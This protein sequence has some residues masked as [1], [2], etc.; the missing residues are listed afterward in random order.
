MLP[1]LLTRDIQ[2]GLKQF[3]LTGFEPSDPHLHGMMARFTSTE[4]Q[5]EWLKGPYLQLGLPFRPGVKGRNFFSNFETEFPGFTHQE[6]AWQRLNT[7]SGSDH[8]PG[9]TLVATGTGSGKTECFVYPMLDH[10]ARALA[11]GERGIK[12]LVIYPMNA[13]ATDQARRLAMMVASTPAFKGLRIGLFV[14]GVTEPGSGVAMTPTGVITDRETM[15]KHPPDVLLTNYKMLDYLLLRPTDRQLWKSNTPTTL[16]HL[17]VD[18]L[19]TF[20][21]A[22]GTDLALLLRRLRARL[23]VPVNHWLCVGT[24]ATL[25]GG[26]G[27]QG[28]APL[29][30]YA[31]QI[32]GSPFPPESVVTE[33]RLLVGEFL[34]DATTDYFLPARSD[35]AEVLDPAR[36]ASPQLAVQAWFTVFFADEATPSIEDVNSPAWRIRLGQMLKH[37]LL[38]SNLLKRVKGD[39]LDMGVLAEQMQGKALPAAANGHL[40]EVIDALLVLVS[41]ARSPVVDAAVTANGQGVVKT[42]PLV[43]VRVQLWLRE[44]RRMVAN[45]ALNPGDVKLQHSSQL[46]ANPGGLHLPLVQCSE[47][48]TTGWLSR[49]PEGTNKLSSKLEEIY[50]TWFAGRPDSTRLY[51]LDGLS[52]PH[53]QVDGV[54]R[55]LCTSCGQL[56][57]GNG[58]CQACGH[59]ELLGVF[60][61]TGLR[62]FTQGN[63]QFTRHDTACP[64]CGTRDRL[65]LLGARNATLGSQVVEHSW[66]SPFNDDKKLIAF[67]DS[68]Q[69][70]A[71]RAGFFGAR[72]YLN[73]VRTALA[74][75]LR[76]QVQAAGATALPWAG[77]LANLE[78][79]CIQP[80]G[81]LHMPADKFVSEFLGP[82]MTW[83]RD[84]VH[85]LQKMGALPEGS[86]LPAK[87]LKRLLWQAYLEFTYLGHRGRT[88]ERV[89]V[90]ALGLPLALLQNVAADL[91]P[92][93]REQFGAQGLRET[94]VVHWLWGF[95]T[96]LR[97]CGAVMHPELE[98]YAQDGNVFGLLRQKARSDWM[99]AMGERTPRP[100]FLSLGQHKHFETLAGAATGGLR[101]NWYE[102]WAAATLG[103]DMLLATGLA[104]E[105]YLT[106]ISALEVAGAMVR[107][108]GDFGESI[109]LAPQSLQLETDLVLLT[110]SAGT[111]RLAVPREAAA[112]LLDMPC[113]DATHEHYTEQAPARG[114]LA[115]R[116]E[117]ADLRRVMAAEHTGLLERKEREAL[118]IRFKDKHPKPWF[119]N[120]LSATPTLEMGVDIGDLSQ[121]LLCS[122]P[123]NQASFL[124]RV[125][126][127]GRRD[128]NAMAATLADGSSPHDL[129]FFDA[130]AE[131]LAGEVAP[132]GV[133][134][135]AAE[136]LRRQLFAYCMDDWVEGLTSATALPVKTST[137]LDAVEQANMSRFPYTFA[138]HV[139]KHEPRL[140]QGFLELLDDDLDDEVRGRLTAFVQGNGDADG[141]RTRLIKA[142]EELAE[143]R[144]QHKK[145][146]LQLDVLVQTARQRPKDEATLAEIDSLLRERDKMLELIAEINGRELLNTLTDAGLIPNYAFPEAGIELKSVL[147]RARAEGEPG[148][149]KYVALPALKYER[150]ANSALSEFAPENRFYA[151]QRRVEVDQINM[152][153][154]K[155]ERWRLCASCHH[156][157]NLETSADV[158]TT[159]PR[160]SDAMWSDE[161]QKRMLLRFKQAIANS[162]DTKVR[163]DDS[164]DDREPRFYVRQLLA[165]FE[166]TDVREAWQLKTGTLPFGF[167]FVSKVSFRDMNFGELAKPGETFKVAD[168]EAV[169]A[170]FKLCKHC[171]KVQTP[172]KRK[173]AGDDSAGTEQQHSFDCKVRDSN[174]PGNIFDCLYLYREFSSEALR[175]LVPYTRH[176]VD[177]GVVQSFMAALQLGLK[178]RFGGKVDHLRV[179]TQDEPGKDGGARRHYVMVYDS[180]PGGTGYLHQLLAGKAGTLADVLTLALA[181]ITDCPCNADPDK[182]GCYR[183][184]YQYR[185]GR[186]MD[187]VSR[188]R[189]REVLSELV[190]AL[191]DMERVKTISEIFINPNFDSVLEARFIESLRRLGLPEAVAASGLPKTKLVQ[192]IVNG[193]SGWLLEVG[194][195]RYKVQPQCDLGPSDGVAVS[196]RPDFVL[197]PWPAT[198]SGANKKR[199]IAVFCDGWSFHKNSIRADALKRSALVAS[200]RFWVWS[201][202]HDDVKAALD[203][204]TVTD[205]ESPLVRMNRHDGLQASPTLARAEKGAFAS[206]G[207]AQLL[208]WLERAGNDAEVRAQHNAI[209]ASFLMACPPG[210]TEA[211]AIEATL[212]SLWQALPDWMH[213]PPSKSL[214]VLSREGVQP[215]LAWRW[216]ASLLKG[217]LTEGEAPGLLLLD[218][219]LADTEKTLHLQWRHWLALFNTMQTLPGFVMMSASGLQAGDCELLKPTICATPPVPSD[220]AALAA[221]WTATLNDTLPAVHGGLRL[222][223]AAGLPPPVAGLE[224]VDGRGRVQAE[225][226][227]AWQQYR[228]AVLLPEQADLASTWQAQGWTVVLVTEEVGAAASSWAEAILEI[229][230]GGDIQ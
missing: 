13:L 149:G 91:A 114:W 57:Q 6:L 69:D 51:A 75:A 26:H 30:E 121:V 44:L 63:A 54:P 98:T 92:R 216:P 192:D 4:N 188:D 167:E 106:A 38:F 162:D 15:R 174:Q 37:H 219:A 229:S 190:S 210:G 180:V 84:W 181:A 227:I 194:D 183:C 8:V 139:L 64:A 22:Q 186:K 205:L 34:G 25:G 2:D 31:R 212:T 32:F 213:P 220:G 207:V 86:R 48:H 12:A 19:H 137:A 166:A 161:A 94:S 193:K 68:V 145:R 189:A 156:M 10:A 141:L 221:E 101:N 117:R 71:H 226:E 195:Q 199:P 133:F 88:L 209:W 179:V 96:H 222:L 118:E 83:Q 173:H 172:Q 80:D 200:G 103:R 11:A 122:V 182:D 126:R 225:A 169:R 1:S 170:G 130:T 46:G 112:A 78:R 23:K 97:Q 159:C 33:N 128:G 187:M 176:G 17:V 42:L 119:E 123:P 202:T 3:L 85:G 153:L 147:W 105:L 171:G 70:A 151:N 218:E 95:V 62:K 72:T 204:K 157:Q 140:L 148:E 109:A 89:G 110:T 203:G 5:A 116:F 24:S 197:W 223:A 228:V 120:L 50:N 191:G 138:D 82:N 163:I 150:P 211:A 144:K 45:V 74:K 131:M 115:N 77:F 16:R 79:Q 125:G 36:Y 168:V 201:I 152:A 76:S 185:L 135:R 27:G 107:T 55:S 66:A 175:I 21:G 111:R 165:D 146:K 143:E 104:K 99:P 73:N 208:W 224:L 100:I 230:K 67:S 87:V 14:G 41:W 53:Y 35:F 60:Q 129:Y 124:Q 49:L 217:G 9:N 108:T 164:A 155:T 7:Q 61:T 215:R 29:R 134:M 178:R 214:P 132:P 65:I 28:T 177:E 81:D 47:C 198:V 158:H 206:N 113:L 102:R 136:V 154:A 196:S 56:Q 20:D 59:H 93:L 18:E 40:R 58:P 142:L 127:A 52:R 43:T 184:V 90:A 160:C 39:V